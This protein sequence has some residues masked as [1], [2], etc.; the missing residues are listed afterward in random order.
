VLFEKTSAHYPFRHI[1]AGGNMQ[2]MRFLPWR[3][4]FVVSLFLLQGVAHHLGE[5]AN[6]NKERGRLGI[7]A[8]PVITNRLV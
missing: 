2:K 7:C 4:S 1:G 8:M 6:K 3:Q 5:D